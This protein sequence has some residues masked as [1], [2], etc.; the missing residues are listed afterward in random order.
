MFTRLC[1]ASLLLIAVA[2]PQQPP[3]AGAAENITIYTAVIDASG[4]PVTGLT[5]AD[6]E[7]RDRGKPQII[8]AFRPDAGPVSVVILLDTSGSMT[9]NI[10]PLRTMLLGLIKSMP[11]ADRLR[12]GSFADV[13]A[14]SPPFNSNHDDLNAAL[15]GSLVVGNPSRL[16]DALD[17]GMSALASESN[18]R[19]IVVLTDGIDTASR[20]STFNTVIRRA[21]ADN[22]SIYPIGLTSG[23]PNIIMRVDMR[24]DPG[25]KKLAAETGGGYVEKKDDVTIDE[26][27][28]RLAAELHAQY[29]LGF[30]P[31]VLDGKRHD[32]EVIVKRA[33]VAVHAPRSYQAAKAK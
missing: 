31:S 11:P 9:G 19:A 3:T 1:A 14:L 20:K 29:V 28:T 13:I 12:V 2:D 32:L 4:H 15:R 16:W 18:R 21:R 24:V 8:T 25:L 26:I 5:Q 27:V 7:I 23:P 30:T 33:K 10:S 17:V 6:F 22:V